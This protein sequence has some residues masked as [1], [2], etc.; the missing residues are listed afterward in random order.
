VDMKKITDILETAM[1][2]L[3]AISFLLAIIRYIY[4]KN[5]K[6]WRND[7]EISVNSLAYDVETIEKNAIY[8][9]LWHDSDYDKIIVFNPKETIIKKI[10]LQEVKPKNSKSLKL[11]CKN[12]EKYKNITPNDSV[13]FRTELAEILPKYRIKWYSDYGE[14]CTWDFSDNLRNGI[15]GSGG[16]VYKTNIISLIRK[17]FG[18]I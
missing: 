16:F 13:C 5:H 9:S 18:F 2:I 3:G 14:Y 10:V 8:S 17:I 7:V 1:T 4:F 15:V 12:L 11:R 6:V